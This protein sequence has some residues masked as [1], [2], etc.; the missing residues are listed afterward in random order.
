M[1]VIILSFVHFSVYVLISNLLLVSLRSTKWGRLWASSGSTSAMSAHRRRFWFTVPHWRGLCYAVTIHNHLWCHYSNARI[2][3]VLQNFSMKLRETGSLRCR[4]FGKSWSC[5]HDK[6]N[7][8]YQADE[9]RYLLMS[10]FRGQRKSEDL[11]SQAIITHSLAV[12]MT[13]S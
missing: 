11:N 4:C 1:T 12:R 2:K 9:N 13:N 10:C 5:S 7:W 6:A 3:H 8:A